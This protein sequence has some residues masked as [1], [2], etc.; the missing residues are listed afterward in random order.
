MAE[1]PEVSSFPAA[2][3]SAEAASLTIGFIG[4]GRAATALATSLGRRWHQ[5]LVAH[6]GGSSAQLAG[7]LGAGARSPIDVL[8]QADITILAVPDGQVAGLARQLA[9]ALAEAEFDGAGRV[10]VHLAGSLGVEVLAALAGRGYEVACMHPLQV[11]SG[12]RIPP[13]T[14]F[15]V[16]GSAAG[17][18]VV[19]RLVRDLNGIELEL[20]AGARP[21]YHAAA[22]V[23]ANLGMA[24]L[25]EAVDLM[26]AAGI[27]RAEALSGLTGLQRGGLE[28][29][30]DKGLPAA[31]TGPVVRGDVDTVRTHLEVLRDDP[32]LLAAYRAVSRL[33]LRQARREGR[34]DAERADAMAQ[35]L[36][37]DR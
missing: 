31:L 15:A 1:Q 14:R 18:Q 20:P 24:L 5:L 3:T 9:D 16:E 4:S 25:A 17:L 27:D 34:P 36:A 19:G 2:S 32:E 6:R 12:W 35:L 23:A 37:D 28:A 33:A 7:R 10:V 26:A 13:G 29:S 22:V 21:A 8:R 30:L 11:L